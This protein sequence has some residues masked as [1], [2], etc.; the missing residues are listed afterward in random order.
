MISGVTATSRSCHCTETAWTERFKL[1]KAGLTAYS[2]YTRIDKF[3]RHWHHDTIN[4]EKKPWA[5]RLKDGLMV[6]TGSVDLQKPD[7][8]IMWFQDCS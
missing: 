5:Y 4:H 7:K 6:A 1:V 2:K 3:S 8:D